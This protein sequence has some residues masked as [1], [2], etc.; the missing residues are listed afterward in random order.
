MSNS[1]SK[2]QRSHAYIPLNDFLKQK[3]IEK[4][5]H[6]EQLTKTFLKKYRK[7]YII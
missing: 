3:Y 2:L 6:I 5:M 7:E 4:N 1:N